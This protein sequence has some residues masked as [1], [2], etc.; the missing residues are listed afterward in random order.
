MADYRL[1]DAEA[2]TKF[3]LYLSAV[4]RQA[5]IRAH[6]MTPAPTLAMD[7]GVG[8][9]R[10]SYLLRERG[11]KIIC[12]DIHPV[13]ISHCHGLMPEATCVLVQPTDTS[14]PCGTGEAGIIVC[15]EVFQVVGASWFIAESS[16][17]LSDGGLIV[18]EFNNKWSWRGVLHHAVSR[19]LGKFDY[20]S[21]SYLTWKREL[22]DIG[23]EIVFEV[24][25]AWF[26]L[27]RRSN[28]P[29]V[30]WGARLERVLGLR[31]LPNFSPT[32][33]FIARKKAV[34]ERP[35]T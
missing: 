24:G 21:K 2:N 5:L 18:G 33:V 27:G 4:E 20:Y 6:E 11:W 29:L 19:F 13:T 26:P 34:V 23:L 9:G 8:G 35:S 25:L 15:L 32:V 31:R 10:W 17:I 14:L 3:G 30:E 16:R 12:T 1:H 28:S 22:R 7:V